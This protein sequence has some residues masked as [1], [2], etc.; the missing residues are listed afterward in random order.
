[1][2]DK[3]Q[4]GIISL[5]V[6]ISIGFFALAAATAISLDVFSELSKDQDTIF[7]DLAF[8]NSE[9][10]VKEGFYQY[11]E[12]PSSYAG[13]ATELINK[14]LSAEI[15]VASLDWPYA[16]IKG[17]AE[18]KL[19]QRK[20]IYAVTLFPEALTFNYAI[21][22]Q[23]EL[24][25]KGN[26]TINGNIFANEKIE[27]QGSGAEVNG[28]AF[29]PN[30]I[31]GAENI[32]GNV[33]TDVEPI[34]PP[35]I[36]LQSY[37]ELAQNEGTFFSTSAEAEDYLNNQTKEALVFIQDPESLGTK[38]QG[39][40][41]RLFG[42]LA[43]EGDLEITGGTFTAS[44]NYPAI[45]VWGDLKITGGTTINGVVYVTGETSFGAG[46]NV[47]NGSLLSVG[48][49]NKT[50]LSGNTTIN[51]DPSLATVWEDLPGLNLVSAGKPRILN[52]RE[53]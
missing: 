40:N 24:N 23:S 49:V 11:R 34:P 20:N 8:H 35:Q 3:K 47:I 6:L 50:E 10:A 9:S 12:N 39:E 28:D 32:E 42:F 37:Y 7:G 21:F 27:F 13:G 45:I 22:S 15:S 17:I 48:N 2:I 16:E 5:L 41:T 51:F 4:K 18:N 46:N 53:E 26:V 14:S 52:W 33:V 1:M 43:V 38:I 25:F 44:E 30:E 19:S 36:D 29:S 31:D